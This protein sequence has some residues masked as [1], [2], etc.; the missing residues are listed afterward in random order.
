MTMAQ[1]TH[2][3]K[4]DYKDHKITFREQ[5][6]IFLLKFQQIFKKLKKQIFCAFLLLKKQKNRP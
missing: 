2:R 6:N 3:E 1:R 5:Y 4:Y